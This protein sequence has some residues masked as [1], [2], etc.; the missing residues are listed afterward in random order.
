MNLINAY[1]EYR[2]ET[3]PPVIFHRWSMIASIASLLG[4]KFYMPFG[5]DNL[6]P[7]QYIM[8]IGGV[9]TRKSTAIK[10]AAK[11]IGIAG[12]N[13]FA[14]RKTSKEKFLMDL[15]G[16]SDDEN[17]QGKLFL[18]M[19]QDITQLNLFGG[20]DTNLLD[21]IPREAFIAADEF[22]EFTIGDKLEFYSMLGDLWD[23]DRTDIA[24]T[25][26]IKG[27]KTGGVS[28]FQ[29]TINIL[30][31][32]TPENF[33]RAF[34]PEVLGQGFM[35]RLLIIAGEVSGRKNHLPEKPI[36]EDTDLIIG[37][38]KDILN[39]HFGEAV[40]PPELWKKGG[41]VDAIYRETAPLNDERF[42]GY[43]QRRYTHLLKLSLVHAII[44]GKV[45]LDEEV[46]Y[47]TNTVLAAAERNMVRALGEFGKDKD[48]D[49]ANLILTAIRE[50]DKPVS[51]MEIWQLVRRHLKNM[52]QV[53]QILN[54]L[55]QAEVIQFVSGRGWLPLIKKT[56]T[57][58]YVD[59]SLLTKEEM[60][61][62]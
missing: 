37:L 26:R 56:D 61:M 40:R 47:L 53:A 59:W 34:P 11:M 18:D 28:I 19:D 54:N 27:S 60:E 1:L 45:V 9:G 46:I 32:N 13:S 23:W 55:R 58:K 36:Q 12:Y 39:S 44:L 50:S 41:L 30:G 7:N 17:A 2:S 16:E 10:Q 43:G 24:Y 6:Y 15:A 42:R 25:S 31:G 14:A 3:E 38:L 62:L 35:S 29:P 51:Q 21:A 22:N 5:S 48:S 57:E 33:A 8:L 4:R 52:S 20:Q 49:V